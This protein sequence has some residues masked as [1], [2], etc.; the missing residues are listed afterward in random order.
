MGKKHHKHFRA[1]FCVASG[2]VSG[3]DPIRMLPERQ[4]GDKC[5]PRLRLENQHGETPFHIS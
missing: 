4:E 2:V 5:D 3:A 1:N